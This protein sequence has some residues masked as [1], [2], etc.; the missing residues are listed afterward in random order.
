MKLW[1]W[2]GRKLH[3]NDDD[4][5]EPDTVEL[6]LQEIEFKVHEAEEKLAETQAQLP[7]LS[8]AVA[9]ARRVKYRVDNFTKAM[10]DDSRGVN[11]G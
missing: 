1:A 7:E 8:R 3:S 11:H 9:S 4:N 10:Y 2:V 5:D 6:P